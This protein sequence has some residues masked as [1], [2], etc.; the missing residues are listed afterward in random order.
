MAQDSEVFPFNFALQFASGELREDREVVM[1][2][3]VQNG[4]A[5]EYASEELRGDR[6]VVMAAVAQT[7]SA[8]EYATTYYKHEKFFLS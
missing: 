1:A 5:L 8:F 6:E 2:A 4:Y 3:V 7:G